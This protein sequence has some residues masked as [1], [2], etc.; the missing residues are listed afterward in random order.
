MRVD[1]RT[2]AS[3]GFMTNIHVV[4]LKLFAPVMDSA[5]SKVGRIPNQANYQIDKIDA[6]YFRNSTRFNIED[7]TKIRA[8]KEEA[9]EYFAQPSTGPPNFISDLFFMLNT[10]QHLGIVKTIGNRMRA[11]KVLG[12]TEKELKRAEASRVDWEGVSFVLSYAD[13]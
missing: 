8:S 4:L 2:V 6:E 5:F 11:E 9:D 12:E 13:F 7:E 10:F 3:D 1:H